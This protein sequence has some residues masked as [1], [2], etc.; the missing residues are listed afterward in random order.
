M[1]NRKNERH[2]GTDQSQERKKKIYDEETKL[3]RKAQRRVKNFAT[4]EIYIGCLLLERI[5][6]DGQSKKE[7]KKTY[8][9]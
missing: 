4:G 1:A 8:G 2:K 5:Q 7:G 6:E 3:R 9:T